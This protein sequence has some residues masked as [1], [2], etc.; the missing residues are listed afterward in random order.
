M[1]AI[2]LD[3]PRVE[4]TLDSLGISFRFGEGGDCRQAPVEIAREN[5][6]ANP[7]VR[8]R[9]EALRPANCVAAARRGSRA[10]NAVWTCPRGWRI[11]TGPASSPR[12]LRRPRFPRAP[13]SGAR[14]DLPVRSL[15]PDRSARASGHD[16]ERFLSDE[17]IRRMSV[18]RLPIRNRERWTEI[19]RP[20][21][22]RARGYP[23]VAGARVRA[24]RPCVP[25]ARA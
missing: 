3:R 5:A 21:D 10:T 12:F 8:S 9:E 20:R 11:S 24:C 13:R 14:R 1:L 25:S 7:V 4:E 22:A 18:E 15:F 19:S 17:E 2:G 6:P 16:F 23:R